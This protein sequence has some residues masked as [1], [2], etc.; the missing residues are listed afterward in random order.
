MTS[1]LHSWWQRIKQNR[2]TI[3]IVGIVLLVVIALIIVGYQFDWTGFKGYNKISTAVDTTSS[4]PKI[5]I[6]KEPQSGKTLW[7][8]L[9]LLGVLA[10][11]AAVGLGTLWFT[12]K[13]GQVSSAENKD[14]QREAALE[15][16]IDKI[17]ELLLSHHLR[18]FTENEEARKIAR[19]RT[20]TVLQRLDG[21]RKG[22]VLQFLQESGLISKDKRIVDLTGANLNGADLELANLSQA[23]LRGDLGGASLSG[24]NMYGADLVEAN[25]SG[26]NLSGANLSGANLSGADLVGANLSGANLSG[27]DLSGA[28]ASFAELDGANLSGAK[29]VG[30]VLSRALVTTEQLSTAESLQGAT[31]PNGSIHS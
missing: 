6:I 17:S 20:L 11:P 28:N 7:D 31:M 18:G 8:W 29:L 24:A 15:A 12:T 26:V 27:A 3:G 4:P 9:Q 1:R 23:D 16:Y 19:V 13:Q 10:I 22:S 21:E 2:V 30:A 25:L 14:N 5:T